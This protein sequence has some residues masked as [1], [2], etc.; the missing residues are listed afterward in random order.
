MDARPRLRGEIDA[1]PVEQEGKTYFVLCDRSGLS[2]AQLV[3]SPPVMVLVTLFDG[4]RS[5]LDLRDDFA[6]MTGGEDVSAGQ[7]DGVLH[8]L[9]EACFLEGEAAAALRER[10]EREFLAAPV[11]EATSAGAVGR[12]APDRKSVV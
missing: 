3:V 7:I 6:E 5:A 10:L 4:R 9:E 12:A 11:R 1:V 2:A 8:A